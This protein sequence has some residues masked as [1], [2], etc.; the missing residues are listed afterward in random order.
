MLDQS[1]WSRGAEEAY[2]A[3]APYYDDFTAHHDYEHWLERLLP[4]LEAHG[5]AGNR[6]LDVACGTGNSFVPML[7][8]GWSVTGCDISPRMVAVARAKFGDEAD[9][10]VA[11]VR[12]L[13]A[14]GEFDLVL[15]LG[16][17]VNYLLDREGVVA[18][19][20][21]I[22]RNLASGGRVLFDANT[23][24]TYRTFFA[25]EE[26]VERED[27]RMIWRGR[28]APDAEPGTTAEATFEV[29]PRDPERP[30]IGP[31]VHHERHFTQGELEAAIEE[32]GLRTLAV[33]GHEAD[34]V[35]HQPLAEERDVKA[36]YIA[37]AV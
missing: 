15:G 24:H 12:D 27:C 17:V 7:R 18:G 2:D 34:V 16:D 28:T 19:L 33:Y 21:S 22:R 11:D 3:I 20:T 8:R 23:L 6:L 13:P 26:V 4:E 1:R 9:L 10:R 37:A 31:D 32:A 35:L 29:Q 25:H 36:I 14:L 30:P 5:L